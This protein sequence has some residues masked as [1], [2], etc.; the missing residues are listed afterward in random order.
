M[1]LPAVIEVY[2][3]ADRGADSNALTDGFAPDAVVTDDGAN[4]L[5]H[6]EIRAWRLASRS[7]YAELVTTPIE[8]IKDGNR[9]VVRCNVSGDSPNSPVVLDFAF[10]LTGDQISKMEIS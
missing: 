9:V 5:G 1:Q 7:K 6:A 3:A 2:F 8:L 10:T 4:Q